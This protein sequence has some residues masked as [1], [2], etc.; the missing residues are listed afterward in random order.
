M[1]LR[2]IEI[3]LALAEELHFGRTAT[4]LCLSPARVTQAIQKQERLI[5]APLFERTNR[6][7]RLTPVGRQ[8]RDDL[9][10]LH[11]GL[12]ESVQRAQLTG[13][14]ITGTL[15]VGMLPANIHDLR[16]YWDA[17]HLRHPQRRLRIQRTRFSDAFAV[18]RRGDIDVLICWLP[19][20]EPDLTVGPVL[21]ADPRVL[22]VAADH[23]LAR[24]T[25]LSL[26]TVADFQHPRP[27]TGPDYW[28]DAYVPR[29]SRRGRPI[30]RGPLVHDTEEAITFTSLAET[31]T[32][33]PSHM[34]RYWV[35]PDIVYLPVH[36]IGPLPYAPVWRSEAENELIRSLADVIRDLGPLPSG[37]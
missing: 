3:F 32:L 27:G 36:D 30:E 31:V 9:Q 8:L 5:G 2:D 1:E 14:G 23:E 17:F 15:R 12:R 35:R 11:A 13:R 6:L 7:V 21:F 29:Q 16:P 19:V 22:A 10:P 20:E 4:R 25:S 28:F 34:A 24:R 18:L 37:S 33:F 26:E